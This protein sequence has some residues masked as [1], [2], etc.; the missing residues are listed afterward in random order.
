MVTLLAGLL[1]AAFAAPPTYEEAADAYQAED[2]ERA[3]ELFEA[4]VESD[5]KPEYLYSLAQSLRRS[6][7]CDRAERSFRRYLAT[8]VTESQLEAVETLIAECERQR[9]ESA[10]SDPQPSKPE[11][12]Q[13]E[14][15]S[16]VVS[17]PTLRP[18]S[19]DNPAALIRG[20]AIGV[21][22]GGAVTIGGAVLMGVFV[23]RT[24]RENEGYD[25]KG[26]GP[27]VDD[28]ALFLTCQAH[29]DNATTASSL[30]F[31]GGVP[32][33]VLGVAGV[34]AGAIAIAVGRRRLAELDMR[35]GLDLQ[36]PGARLSLRF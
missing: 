16:P 5:P 17:D 22:I 32:A 6:H 11:G 8:G 34:T 18:G 23:A 36:N 2:F 29:Q 24:Q 31:G 1:F 35:V 10:Q 33:L 12:P 7:Q 25:E 20:G 9:D 30:A 28:P 3:A 14:E 27:D 13:V 4:L 15:A 26:C 21:S 19:E